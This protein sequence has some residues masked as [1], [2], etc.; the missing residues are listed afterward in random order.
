MAGHNSAKNLYLL[1]YLSSLVYSKKKEDDNVNEYNVECE[2]SGKYAMWTR[3]DTGDCPVSY[4]VPTFSAVKGI[5]SSVLWLPSVEIAPTAVVVCS[6]IRYENY[7]TNYGGPL[8]KSSSI[9]G[10]NSY[11]LLAT[12]LVDVC[13]KLY[14]KVFPRRIRR[15]A[16]PESAKEWDKLTTSPGHAYMDI[17]ERRIKRGQTHHIP[18]L[19]WKEFVPD[20]FGMCRTQ[21]EPC[22]E[23]NQVIPSMLY[24]VFSNGYD[25]QPSFSFVHNVKIT[26]GVLFFHEKAGDK[27]V[28]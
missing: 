27:S 16:I 21:S 3:P 4:P 15:E 8:R 22:K 6:P 28:E 11:Q 20:Y 24:D 19:G 23:V 13:Y 17:F 10:G 2:I 26:N 18:F 5:F 12:V 7:L 14:A 25:T 9:S 1:T